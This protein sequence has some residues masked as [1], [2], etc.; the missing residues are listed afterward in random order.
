MV[1]GDQ[2][3]ASADARGVAQGNGA[4]MDVEFGGIEIQGLDVGLDLRGKGFVD[5]KQIHVAEGHSGFFKGHG[6][7]NSRTFTHG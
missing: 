1:S 4:A 2:N 6:N 5:F 7:D 3:P